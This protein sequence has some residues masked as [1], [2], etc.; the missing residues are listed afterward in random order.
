MDALTAS[1][2]GFTIAAMRWST[3]WWWIWA[4]AAL[5]VLAIFNIL[6]LK[7]PSSKEDEY[8]FS[9]VAKIFMRQAAL[10]SLAF[11]F[12]VFWPAV[13]FA[14]VSSLAKTSEQGH[15]WF[16][17]YVSR[18]A[19]T[20]GW[21]LP[22]GFGVGV[23]VRMAWSRYVTPWLSQMEQRRLVRQE[24]EDRS[25]MRA[26]V[27]KLKTRDFE[28][29]KYYKPGEVFLGLGA[30]NKPTYLSAKTFRETHMQVVGPT[31][32]G[33]GVLLG[34]MLEQAIQAGDSVVYIDPK[35]DKFVPYIMADA[36]EKAGRKFIYIDLNSEDTRWSPFEGGSERDRRSR[37]VN[38]FGLNNTGDGSDFYKSKE[39]AI[40]DT[41]LPK[42]GSS[43]AGLRAA[44]E[45]RGDDGK[46]LKENANRLYDG[47]TEF[48][49]LASLNPKKGGG[50]KI[51]EALKAGAS[52]YVR[53]SLDDPTV[54][55]ATQVLVSELI[56]ESRRL[57]NERPCHL[58]LAIDE[59]KFMISQEVSDALATIA[60]FNVNMILLHQSIR[61]LRAPEDRSL[62]VQALESG[63]I[64]NCQVKLMY[65]A[66]DPETAEWASKLSG[67]KLIR[68][69][70]SQTVEH[71]RYGGEAYKA[72]RMLTDVDVPIISENEMLSLSP[73]VGVFFVPD[74]LASVVFTCFVSA[75][76]QRLL[77]QRPQEKVTQDTP[78]IG[79]EPSQKQAPLAT[80]QTG[81][82]QQDQKPE[83]QQPSPGSPKLQRVLDAQRLP[84]AVATA[85]AQGASTLEVAQTQAQP[86]K[87]QQGAQA[88]VQ[89]NPASP[90]AAQPPGSV[91]QP[92][93]QNAQPNRPPQG[94]RPEKGAQQKSP[95]PAQAAA[96]VGEKPATVNP[97]QAKRPQPPSQPSGQT[98]VKAPT[99]R[100]QTP[101]STLA[102]PS[103]PALATITM[104][105][106]TEP[107]PPSEPAAP[108]TQAVETATAERA[109][110][111]QTSA[112]AHA[113]GEVKIDVKV[114]AKAK[115]PS[116]A[117]RDAAPTA[118][119]AITEAV[120]ETADPW[121]T[122]M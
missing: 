118:P 78:A 79:N 98:N 61:D 62:N 107:P 75:N 93:P 47:L 40:L 51:G 53:G 88:Q 112:P 49:V 63:V 66:S 4:A 18:Q 105:A 84:A 91:Q 71:N 28:P 69:T 111:I 57:V 65:R 67:T 38:C 106:H 119:A 33:K 31:R 41:I 103:A 94:P 90:K 108:Q 81:R 6:P 36:C 52:I 70:K 35:A 13:Y 24:D 43:I 104:S 80:Q 96:A 95:Q 2:N 97:Q 50:N 3:P 22:V 58:T 59:L 60:G 99:Q 74:R 10:G 21:M 8:G 76:T 42:S 37:I 39:R 29:R 101:P 14:T 54:K 72:E 83:T 46:P 1:I 82:P 11:L 19:W 9:D 44:L 115:V 77:Y 20:M 109:L 12:L 64:V 86:T 89:H 110:P 100:A 27:G 122:A 116:N 87:A 114:E 120:L 32:F 85:E 55:R 117:S 23:A 92:Q 5:A 25:D 7:I 26:E 113:P 102:E 68:V 17:D 48:S 56:Q 34:V 73:R 121:A 15:Q 16:M 45:Q 30:D